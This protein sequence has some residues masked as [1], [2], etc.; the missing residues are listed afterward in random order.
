MIKFASLG[1]MCLAAAGIC[2]AASYTGRLMDADC[3][4]SKKV[5][6]RDAGHKTY[7]AITKTCAATPATTNFA[8]RV[9]GNAFHEFEG[10][11][12]RLDDKGDQM[13]ASEMKSEA[14]K[15]GKDG[16]V[17]VQVRGK[18][19]GETLQSADVEPRGSRRA[20]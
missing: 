7:S 12:I 3:Y 11:T 8:V 5:E 9:T 10:A 19:L 18:L 1:I 17:R 6:S 16:I 13:A 2:S 14:L 4:N 20:G 15:P